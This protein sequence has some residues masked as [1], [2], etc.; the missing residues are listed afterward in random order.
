MSIDADDEMYKTKHSLNF[1]ANK[2]EETLSDC[3]AEKRFGKSH[4]DKKRKVESLESGKPEKKT[5]DNRQKVAE[6]CSAMRAA[7]PLRVGSEMDHTLKP[8]GDSHS[9]SKPEV[10]NKKMKK[11]GQVFP[12]SSLPSAK[13]STPSEMNRTAAAQL[14]Y[15]S[16][17]TTTY[18]FLSSSITFK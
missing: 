12:D 4:S 18:N 1:P 11:P 15:Q 9:I 10:E 3:T 5:R 16:C 13:S 14:L 2:K 8:C 7:I 6:T 17:G